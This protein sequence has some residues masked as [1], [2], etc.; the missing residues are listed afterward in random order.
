MAKALNIRIC[1]DRN[2]A[3]ILVRDESKKYRKLNLGPANSP[4]ALL[5][6]RVGLEKLDC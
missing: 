1:K 3:Y 6:Y 4:E 2:L 5:K